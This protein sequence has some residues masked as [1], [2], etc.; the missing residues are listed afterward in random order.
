VP[1]PKHRWL[2]VGPPAVRP[3]ATPACRAWLNAGIPATQVAEW[4]GNSVN[5]LL[6]F[7]AKRLD[8]GVAATLHRIG[9]ALGVQALDKRSSP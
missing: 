4:A 5:V 8:G 2:P 3:S 9:F 1:S 7:Y 6:D